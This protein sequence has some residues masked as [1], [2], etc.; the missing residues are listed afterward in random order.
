M[1]FVFFRGEPNDGCHSPEYMVD[2]EDKVDTYDEKNIYFKIQFKDLYIF[3][4]QK[5]RGQEKW[6]GSP[7]WSHRF[8]WQILE[9]GC[10]KVPAGCSSGM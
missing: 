6:F 3:S 5:G 7:C 4:Q 8:S 10:M 1:C 9:P 2:K